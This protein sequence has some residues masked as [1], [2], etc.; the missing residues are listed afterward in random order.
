MAGTR[1][2][3]KANVSRM[4]ARP[5]TTIRKIG[6]A[7]DSLAETSMLD[8][9][10]PPTR[11]CA[12]VWPSIAA[13]SSRIVCTRVA[14][15]GSPGPDSGISLIS[16]MPFCVVTGATCATSGSLV[17]AAAICWVSAGLWTSWATISSGPL[18]PAPKPSVVRS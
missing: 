16:A 2:V 15:A 9:V 1:M 17:R 6:R 10:V 11:M 7:A 13:R 14:V 5:T 12:P 18:K 3:R 8:A 4:K